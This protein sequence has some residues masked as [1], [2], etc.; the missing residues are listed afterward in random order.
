MRLWIVLL[1][2]M[3]SI[4]ALAQGGPVPCLAEPA[5]SP[6]GKEIAFVSSGDIWTV[7]STG[8]EAR[9]LV[10]HSAAESRPLYSPD[11]KKLAFVSTRSGGG[12]LFVL[13]LD[14]G[15]TRRLTWGDGA[16]HLD[17]WSPDSKYLYFTTNT[18]EVSSSVSDVFRIPADGGT[19][20]PVAHE[21]YVNEFFA[22]PRPDGKTI[23]YCAGGMSD[24]TW[25]RR[26]F[27]HGDQTEI[28]L[29]NVDD[30]RP[31]VQKLT[32][33]GARDLWPMWA[34]DGGTL[35]FV[36]DASGAL[37]LH[38]KTAGGQMKQLTTFTN[39]RIHWPS[40]SAGGKK[41]VFERGI[42]LW[43][44]DIDEAQAKPL[45]IKLR[46]ASAAPLPDHHVFVAFE[47]MA[48]SPDGRKVALVAHGEIFAAGVKEAGPVTRVTRTTAI[49][50]HVTWSRDSR[51]IAYVSN[52]DGARHIFLYDFGTGEEFRLTRGEVDDTR[53]RFSPDSRHI[54]FQRDGREIRMIDLILKK[55]RLLVKDQTF[56]R[57]PF[58]RPSSSFIFSPA[59]DW[60]A[61]ATMG[62]KGFENVHVIATSGRE[63]PRQVTF[64]ANAGSNALAWAPSGQFLLFGTGQRTEDYQ[65]A[66]VDLVPRTP[67]FRE[68]QFKDLFKETRPVPMPR[69]ADG[70]EDEDAEGPTTRPATTSTSP[71]TTTAS[72]QPT[73]FI[74]TR[75]AEPVRVFFDD[76]RKRLTLINPGFDVDFH[77][78]SPDGKTALLVGTSAGQQNLYLYPLDESVRE[79]VPRQLT[80]T[81]GSKS[82]VQFS[83]DGRE[84]LF[85][86]SGK[87]V[88]LSIDTRVAAALPLT[89][90][91]ETDFEFDKMQVFNQVW[92]YLRDHF[93]DAKMGG[94]DWQSI[95]SSFEPRIAGIKTQEEL[96]RVL[97][98]MMG[99]LNASHL[100]IS[101]GT[102][103]R[104]TVGRLGLRFDRAQYDEKRRL[105]IDSVLPL[106]PAAIAGIRE[107]EYLLAV[108]NRPVDPA[109]NLDQLLNQKIG[110]RVTLRISSNTDFKAGRDVHLLP[111]DLATER[112]L[113]YRAW[114]DSKRA[115]VERRSNGKIGYVHIADMSETALS[116]L[117]ADL[118]SENQ[119]RSA[120]IVDVRN[121]R[122]GFVNG[123]VVDV[124]AR[125]NYL[126]MVRRGYAPV[127]SRV[128]LGQRSLDV[129]TALVTNRNTYSDGEDFSEA[130]RAL[131][132]GKIIGEPTAGSV[133]FTS[134]VTLLDGSKLGLPH[135][136]VLGQDGK[137]L[138]GNPRPV[139]VEIRRQGG[140][141][142]AKEDPQLD[143]AMGAMAGNNR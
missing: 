45:E 137:P 136:T 67:R 71:A 49:E 16:E 58:D 28:Y 140:E 56:E 96:R 82:H 35:Y 55:E 94:A 134:I 123:F 73:P 9:L 29:A 20:M 83:P 2:A 70:G 117:Y 25:W 79:P 69:K 22:A 63:D 142:Y 6:D 99:E 46:G 4:N 132:V 101:S 43:I 119:T 127:P 78:I 111:V 64:L 7:P 76:I 14:T 104:P 50:S 24:R 84:V 32:T 138:E 93:A 103:T 98:L 47:E 114:V 143:A 90:E 135:T 5:L 122:G 100:S 74:T 118:D 60:I 27:N 65:L 44:Y 8:G 113:A 26:G 11:G 54:A 116:K 37:N 41:I 125:R 36:S 133:I 39:G 1:A 121:N 10:A 120:V 21:P 128:R 92:T 86:E 107:G 139:D 131:K 52:R 97:L 81:T 59:G 89:A 33:G 18:A 42:G 61:F 112:G 129:P 102:A 68:D 53:P 48:L 87:P 62:P 19:P 105:R 23:A 15:R 38:V 30:K 51:R 12:D 13:D 91:M 57:A 17:A 85:L 31:E 106:S 72:S 109:T 115:Y 34:P 110:K 124:F 80:S 40:L 75:P 88:A 141:G 77:T 108:D 3:L 95:R 66:R 130:W 126:T